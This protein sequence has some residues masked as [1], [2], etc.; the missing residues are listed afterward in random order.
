MAKKDETNKKEENEIKKEVVQSIKEK[1]LSELNKEIE[2]TLIS[3][4]SKFK[5]DLKEE[6]SN[7]IQVEVA[8]LMKQE[9]K[10]IIKGKNMAIFKR[11][12]F[13]LIFFGIT[14]YFGYCLYDVKYFDFMKAECEKNGTCNG[15]NNVINYP[16]NKEPTPIVKDKNWYIENYGYLMEEIKV[17]M[18]PDQVSAYYL[19]SSDH[20]LSDIKTSYLLNMAYNHLD[21]KAIKTNSMNI[22]VEGEVLRKAYEEIFGSM[23]LYQNVN[24]TYDCLNFVYNQ[25]KDRFVAENEK[26]S[27][28][29]NA[30]V[31]EIDAMNEEGD[32]LYINTI[33]SIY[34]EREKSF[35]TFD[36][37]YE[38]AVSN[39][40]REDLSKYAKKLNRY[41]YQFKK[42]DNVYYLDSITKLK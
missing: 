14:L 26:C 17:T 30:I 11:D 13:I 38:A 34:N 3:K 27:V 24:F 10:R 28:S 4:T 6:M 1:V 9:E 2:T 42:V 35:Y 20:Q 39:V 36:D 41:Q 21:K 32:V 7:D 37:L 16:E 12:L 8:N 15:D 5:D 31:E 33:A 22:T 23:N 18:N 40:T 25:E 29:K 19:Y